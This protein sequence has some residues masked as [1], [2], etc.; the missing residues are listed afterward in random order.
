[1]AFSITL[2]AI[3]ESRKDDLIYFDPTDTLDPVIGFNP[4]DFTDADDLDP[5]DKENYLTL[6]AGETYTI[7]ERASATSA[8]K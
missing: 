6:K 4:F 1:M 7:F 3:P 5:R 8:L 2:P